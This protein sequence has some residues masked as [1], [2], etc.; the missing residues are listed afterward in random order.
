MLRNQSRNNCEKR[1]EKDRQEEEE[2]GEGEKMLA[3]RRSTHE[4][5]KRQ[6]RWVGLGW[7]GLTWFFVNVGGASGGN[8]V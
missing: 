1:K 5:W 8:P 7:D 3:V 4:R 6:G 2:E